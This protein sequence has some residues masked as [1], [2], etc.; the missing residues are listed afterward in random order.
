MKNENIRT[1]SQEQRN[2]I[3]K[4]FSTILAVGVGFSVFLFMFAL[5]AIP[6]LVVVGFIFLL[7]N[8]SGV[9]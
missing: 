4:F 5:P 8:C 2:S 1:R 7:L 6:Y 3:K 9:I